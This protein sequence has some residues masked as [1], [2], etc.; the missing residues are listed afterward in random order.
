METFA[1]DLLCPFVGLSRYRIDPFIVP[2]T[3]I[4]P[5]NFISMEY[6]QTV[7]TLLCTCR[8]FLHINQM[9]GRLVTVKRLKSELG[10]KFNLKEEKRKGKKNKEIARGSQRYKNH[11]L[12]QC[13]VII[14]MHI[15]TLSILNLGIRGRL[16]LKVPLA[17]GDW[18]ITRNKFHR[19]NRRRHQAAVATLSR[20]VRN[21]R[22]TTCR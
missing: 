15:C 7:V 20:N 18:R 6:V 11:S 17:C 21:C 5:N 9:S 12:R 16:F 14:C 2:R 4:M 22:Q 13:R 3:S 1:E 19:F 8:L 10:P